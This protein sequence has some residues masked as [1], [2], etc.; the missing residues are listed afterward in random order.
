VFYN[1]DSVATYPQIEDALRPILMQ[2]N[3]RCAS[4]R[5]ESSKIA[6]SLFFVIS[7]SI[8]TQQQTEWD[9]YWDLLEEFEFEAREPLL[10]MKVDKYSEAL[11]CM[12]R[13][14]VNP[15][16]RGL[17][18]NPTVLSYAPDILSQFSAN[19]VLDV[20][21]HLNIDL[22]SYFIR[23]NRYAL[24]EIQVSS[25]K[26]HAIDEYYLAPGLVTIGF[27]PNLDARTI[28]QSEFVGLDINQRL[29]YYKLL[30]RFVDSVTSC[31]IKFYNDPTSLTEKNR[32]FLFNVIKNSGF[33]ELAIEQILS[34]S[35]PSLS[36]RDSFL[37][38]QNFKMYF[39]ENYYK[40]SQKL[41]MIFTR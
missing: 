10:F 12:D 24:H 28:V 34:H 29:V 31:L 20:A 25:Q 18:I 32:K 11:L 9:F 40:I 8:D 37:L 5:A 2:N 21:V 19:Y 35:A 14:E 6:D 17:G 30:A 36:N 4:L 16:Y 33:N 39:A 22:T 26:L 13:L 41:G 27:N 3:I 38:F 1:S 15:R 23:Q 7:K